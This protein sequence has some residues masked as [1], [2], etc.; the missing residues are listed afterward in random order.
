MARFSMRFWSPRS[1]LG[2]EDNSCPNCGRRYGDRMEAAAPPGQESA[3]CSCFSLLSS[4]NSHDTAL[5]SER[6]DHQQ[7][8]NDPEGNQAPPSESL[9]EEVDLAGFL[10]GFHFRMAGGAACPRLRKR[11]AGNRVVTG[12]NEPPRPQF[13]E[14]GPAAGNASV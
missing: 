1:I 7:K 2:N 8:E 14:D 13:K 11:A 3:I 5:E 10:Q 12:C 9:V 4:A 6:P